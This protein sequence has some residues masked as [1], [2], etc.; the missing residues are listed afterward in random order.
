MEESLK[1]DVVLGVDLGW[2]SQLESLGFCWLDEQNEVVDPIVA[3]KRLGADTV[4]LRVFVDPPSYGFWVKP[5]KK[6]AEHKIPGGLVM[7]GFC[8]KDSVMAMS[9][10][11]KALDMKLM[12]DFH[13]SDHFADPVF[14]DIPKAWS[15]FDDRGLAE[16]VAEHTTDVLRALKDEGI[17]PEY[18]QIGNEINNGLLL[19]QGSIKEH[20]KETVNILNSAYEAVK[21]VF[22]ETCVVTHVSVGHVLKYV[23]AFFDTY[24]AYGGYSDMIG[25]SY[26]P[27]WFEER[28]DPEAFLEVLNE[29]HRLYNKDIILS[30]IGGR[31]SEEEETYCLLRDTLQL[32]DKTEGNA[33]KGV[34]Y[35]EPE[36]NSA[37]LPDEYPLG[38]ARLVEKKTLQYT[39][40][41]SAYK[42]Y[43]EGL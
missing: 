7:L 23:R 17:T 11:V 15:S 39:K 10:R 36:A 1:S 34:I 16:K 29:I 31:D 6:V 42:N 12:I 18:V 32:M 43:R 8:D 40:A 2:V 38:A 41:L 24:F 20:P 19:P 25:L 14:Q 27:A 21:A 33:L 26:Y 28:H 4:R 13:Y 35:W 30:E 9:K 5:E 37:A 22:P 3:A